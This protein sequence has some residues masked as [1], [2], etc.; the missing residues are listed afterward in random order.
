MLEYRCQNPVMEC[1]S[2]LTG[3]TSNDVIH[4][5]KMASWAH[6]HSEFIEGDM[7]V[8]PRCSDILASNLRG[9]AGPG[10]FIQVPDDDDAK[11]A[12][13][14]TIN[15]REVEIFAR[16]DPGFFENAAYVANKKAEAEGKTVPEPGWY[17]SKEGDCIFAYWDNA[18]SYAERINGPI[19][20][21]RALD[22]NRIVGCQLKGVGG[23]FAEQDKG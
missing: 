5:I 7:F 17:Q 2:L 21:Y 12:E 11:N 9:Y 19:T 22:D 20:I 3:D 23:Q 6:F 15:A 10:A 16:T 18:P 13:I 4:R 8:C 14:V 1:N